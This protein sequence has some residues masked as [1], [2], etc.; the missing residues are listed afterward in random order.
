MEGHCTQSVIE[1]RHFLTEVIGGLPA[2]SNLA[3][4]LRGIRAVCRQ[5]LDTLGPGG[6]RLALSPYVFPEPKKDQLTGRT[7]DVLVAL[8]GELGTAEEINEALVGCARCCDGV[9][10]IFAEILK[11]IALAS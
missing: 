9:Q 3:E 1:I 6:R 5:F 11:L 10:I 8:Y 4:H 7:P 2:D